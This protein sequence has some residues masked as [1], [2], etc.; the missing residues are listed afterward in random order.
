VKQPVAGTVGGLVA[1]I[2]APVGGIADL[3]AGPEDRA[4]VRR[5]LH[6]GRDR[7]ETGGAVADRG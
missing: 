4:H 1:E 6:H 3:G 2:L 5:Q 7:R